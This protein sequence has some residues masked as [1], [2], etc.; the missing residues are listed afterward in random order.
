MITFALRDGGMKEVQEFE[1]QFADFMGVKYAV[2]TSSGTMADIIAL[3]VLKEKFPDKKKVL[4]PALTF[5]AQLNAVLHNGLEPVFY[6]TGGEF[7]ITSKYE[8]LCTFPVHLLGKPFLIFYEDVPMIEDSCEAL[9]SKFDG[10]F[11]GTMGDMGTFSFYVTHTLTTGEGGMIV[12]NNEEYASIAR[13]LRDHGHSSEKFK[14]DRIGWNGKMSKQAALLGLE[15]MKTLKE[16]LEKR[17][18]NY[19][20]LGGKENKNEYIVPHGFPAYYENRDEKMKELKE[21]G[22]DSRRIFSSLPTQ[23]K[24]YTFLGYKEGDFPIAEE[25]GRTG[26]YVPCHQN[27]TKEELDHIKINL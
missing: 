18:E 3:G 1:K 19:L 11:C 17:H 4:L 10:K 6:D 16:D 25:I 13:S 7:N 12:T 2:A 22:I 24:A 26:L 20:Y 27:L 9:G 23:E 14:F 8:L 5:A 21:K 15:G